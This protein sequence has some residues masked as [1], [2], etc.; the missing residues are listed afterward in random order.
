MM[1]FFYAILDVDRARELVA[2]KVIKCGMCG[3]DIAAGFNMDV[4]AHAEIHIEQHAG[5]KPDYQQRKA[6]RLAGARNL[7][8]APYGEQAKWYG[9]LVEKLI[10]E[11]QIDYR[12][13]LDQRILVPVVGRG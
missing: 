1:Q 3:Q 8:C 9:T 13:L 12:L 4:Q 7:E 10:A 2:G 6:R 11:K 5:H